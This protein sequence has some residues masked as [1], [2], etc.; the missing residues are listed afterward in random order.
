[1]L[2][3]AIIGLGTISPMHR[4]AIEQS[5]VAKLCCVCDVKPERLNDYD[6]AGYTDIDTML[7]KESIDC[8]HICLPHYLHVDVAI[9]CAKKGIHVFTEKPVAVSYEQASKLFDLE[10]TTGVKVG[11]CLQNRYN[12]TSVAMKKIY[13]D[14]EYGKFLGSKGL[15]SWCRP[16]EYYNEAPWRAELAQ[17]GGG[18]MINQAIHTLDLLSYI[19]TDFSG[20]EAKVAQFSGLGVEV[21][22]SV[23]ARLSYADSDAMAIFFATTA[24]ANNSAVELSFVFEKA[25][26]TILNGKLYRCGVGSDE[27]E[28]ICEDSTLHG[29]KQYYGASHI[30]A[31]NG[32]YNAVIN[33]TKDYVSVGEAA[34]SVKVIDC[35]HRSNNLNTTVKISV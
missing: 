28:L 12:E 22:D 16:A 4:N 15:V 19:C 24:Y 10:K 26:F 11:V 7:E 35:I 27:K 9:K 34:Y 14:G 17:A 5:K 18:V 6:V 33:D 2:R 13:K 23:M 21:E 20:V 3:V 31:I 25:V 30:L 8:V 1:M 29:T 32:F